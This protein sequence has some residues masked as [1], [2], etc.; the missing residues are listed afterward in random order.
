MVTR[1]FPATHMPVNS[2]PSKTPGNE[3]IEEQVVD[4]QTGI[5][6]IRMTKIVPV[7]IDS[8]ARMKRSN[9]I[10]PTLLEQPMIGRSSLRSK[11]RVVYPPFRL[12]DVDVRGHHVVIAGEDHRGISSHELGSTDGQTLEPPEL[13]IELGTGRR[14]AIGKIE[15][16][17]DER[18]NACFDVA[19]VKVIGVARQSP[20]NFDGIASQRKDSHAVIAFLSV[21]NRAVA[22]F[23]DFLFRKFVLRGLELLQAG[24]VRPALRQP[25]QQHRKASIHAIHIVGGDPHVKKFYDRLIM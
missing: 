18:T 9:R 3:G 7:R 13:V 1:L 10:R 6:R 21:P 25:A 8:F 17:D 20:L 16:S 15:T 11:Q 14:I 23:A 22:C 24:N 19:A 5:A 12:V 4:A 2:C